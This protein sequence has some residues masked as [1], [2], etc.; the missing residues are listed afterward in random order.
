MHT[1]ELTD[2]ALM[3]EE[4]LLLGNGD[5]S[6]SVYQAVDRII[7]RFGK[8]DV[9]DRRHDHHIDPEPMH[10]DELR[11]GI[12]EE[13]WEFSR[14]LGRA[15]ATKGTDNDERVA[16]LTQY[17]S[18]SYRTRPYPC[19]KPVGEL[20]MHLPAD[21][22]HLRIHQTLTIEHGTVDIRCQWDSGMRVDIHCFV[23][24]STNA[25]AVRWKVTGADLSNATWQHHAVWFSLY[26]WADPLP[27]QFVADRY[28]R[29]DNDMFDKYATPDVTPMAPPVAHELDGRWIIEQRF[30]PDL[31][32]PEGFRYGL[33]PMS[34]GMSVEC[35]PDYGASEARLRIWP[36]G[37]GMEGW[38]AVAMGA[39][40]DPGG[41]E[42]QLARAGDALA[43]SAAT[44]CEQWGLDNLAESASFWARSAVSLDDNLLERVWY[45]NLHTRRCTFRGDV[46][47]PGLY[48]PSTVSDFSL[49][50]GDYH[51][52]YNYQQPFWGGYEANQISLGDSYFPGFEHMLTLG[53]QLAKDFY[54]CR[55]VFVQLTGFPFPIAKDP[56]CVGPFARMTYMTGWAVNQYWFRWLYTQDEDWLREVGYPPI[57]D[58]AL[59]YLDFLE[60]GEDGLYHGFPSDQGEN[61]FT[62]EVDKYTDRPQVMRHVRYC[63][64]IA[65]EAAEVLGVDADL[66]EQWRDV[67]A[68]FPVIDDLDAGGFTDEQKRRYAVNPPEFLGWEDTALQATTDQPAYL[69]HMPDNSLWAWYFGHFPIRWMVLLRRGLFQADRDFEA[70]KAFVARWRQPNGL[71]RA[72]SRDVYDF[73]GGWSESLGILAPIQEMLL[74]SWDGAIRV[75]PAWPKTLNGSFTTLRAQG[76]FL[77]SADQT[78][79]EVGDITIHSERGRPCCVANPWPLTGV[80]RDD[81]GAEVP[82]T[83][84]ER[85]DDL[86]WIRF[87]TEAG[88]TYTV[89]PG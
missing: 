63:M 64:D 17:G 9:W 85:P 67:L 55:G 19:P 25:L 7:W 71:I 76:A 52:N 32:Y 73:S 82:R 58:A 60:K 1:I 84:D 86:N 13:G 49:W 22:H 14:Q 21:Q 72:M 41:M 2:L 40:S 74:Q 35:V 5:F 79:G 10:I 8:V 69:A 56:Y 30:E 62:P 6:V 3:P 12:A 38:L 36:A 54:N 11:R 4:G 28:S 88:K 51:T 44:V 59:F 29:V 20:S 16:E 23:A 66:V 53:R 70:A 61:Q 46:C 18:P 27:A 89:S 65:I 37:A 77:V 45:E 87:E 24:P 39:S 68:N 78:D 75:F 42:A 48:L 57:H 83:V 26:R 47:A 34:D 50:H 31:E 15:A 81:D 33:L 43:P 80:V